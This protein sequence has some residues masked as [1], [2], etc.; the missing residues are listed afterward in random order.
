MLSLAK[1]SD[2]VS[3]FILIIWYLLSHNKR[4]FYS[5]ILWKQKI[6]KGKLLGFGNIVIY[7]SFRIIKNI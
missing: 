6:N 7:Y 5:E 2:M 3:D 1:S 4:D